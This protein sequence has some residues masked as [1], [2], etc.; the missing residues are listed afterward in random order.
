MIRIH[1]VKY[2]APDTGAV[3]IATFTAFGNGVM[4]RSTDPE[5]RSV[6]CDAI[7]LDNSRAIAQDLADLFAYAIGSGVISRDVSTV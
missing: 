3:E 2:S 7:D 6:D 1:E 5:M 4:I